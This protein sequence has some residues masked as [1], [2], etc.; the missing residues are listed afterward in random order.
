MVKHT[1]HQPFEIATDAFSSLH[2]ILLNHHDISA[3]FLEATAPRVAYKIL[4]DLIE[5]FI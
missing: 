4:Y 1:Q 5:C 3:E 2:D